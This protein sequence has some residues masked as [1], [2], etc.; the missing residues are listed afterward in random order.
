M[1]VQKVVLCR[2][3]SYPRIG[4]TLVKIL[5]RLRQ[6]IIGIEGHQR[7]LRIR[8]AGDKPDIPH[9]HIGAGASLVTA[10]DLK[11]VWPANGNGWK[12]QLEPA[13]PG[14]GAHGMGSANG[15]MDEGAGRGVAAPDHNLLVTLDNRVISPKG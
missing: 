4:A 15:C 9:Q 7:E 13:V 5:L 8:L 11:C 3:A 1:R 10:H 14:C 2:Q 6:R 12:A